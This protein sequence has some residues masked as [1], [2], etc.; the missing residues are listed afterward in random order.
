VTDNQGIVGKY[1][2]GVY[3]G[4]DEIGEDDQFAIHGIVL[5]D[6]GGGIYLV[7]YWGEGDTK[8]APGLRLISIQEMLSKE[9]VGDEYWRFF[10]E[11]SELDAYG[12]F[13]FRKP[14]KDAA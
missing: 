4:E 9:G 10:T 1:F 7:Q 11:R 2:H 3:V 8:P 13:W 6:L 12:S 14:I 5:G